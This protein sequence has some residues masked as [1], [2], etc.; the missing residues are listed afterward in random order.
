MLYIRA[1]FGDIESRE[2]ARTSVTE[3]FKFWIKQL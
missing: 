1:T 3:P 2:E